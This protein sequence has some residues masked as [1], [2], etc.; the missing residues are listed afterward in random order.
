MRLYPIHLA[1]SSLLDRLVK[2]GSYIRAER[3][4]DPLDNHYFIDLKADITGIMR[5]RIRHEASQLFQHDRRLFWKTVAM[6][7]PSYLPL[8]SWVENGRQEVN[9]RWHHTLRTGTLLF[10]QL[11]ELS[12]FEVLQA[13]IDRETNRMTEH[14]TQSYFHGVLLW[15][16]NRMDL[17]RFG[18]LRSYGPN[19]H[20]SGNQEHQ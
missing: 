13:F 18:R 19:A 16:E 2:E 15:D 10:R 12:M 14:F 11:D 5:K 3:R 6:V 4:E 8:A 17:I 9:V 1:K 20:A 7:D